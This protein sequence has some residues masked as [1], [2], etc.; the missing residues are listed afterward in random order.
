[1]LKSTPAILLVLPIILLNIFLQLQW[2]HNHW[3][4]LKV[5]D[6]PEE[7]I[8]SCGPV[9]KKY[10]TIQEDLHKGFIFPI[11]EEPSGTS[12]TG[13]Q[14]IQE[15]HGYFIVSGKIMIIRSLR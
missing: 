11:G 2:L 15:G 4:G 14:S 7:A 13:F 10:K 5:Q 9:I 1:M 8:N 6:I 3:R 12:W